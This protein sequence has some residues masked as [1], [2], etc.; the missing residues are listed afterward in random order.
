MN[1]VN[2]GVPPLPHHFDKRS[3]EKIEQNSGLLIKINPFRSTATE[4]AHSE[5]QL[6]RA[7]C[8]IYLHHS[9]EMRTLSSWNMAHHLF[10]PDEMRG[11]RRWIGSQQGNLISILGYNETVTSMNKKWHIHFYHCSAK[12][13][14]RFRDTALCNLLA[15]PLIQTLRMINNHNN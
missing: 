1:V 12:R 2:S 15:A 4:R 9:V 13:N 14:C 3:A 10:M 8:R 7:L 5:L 6:E 11:Q